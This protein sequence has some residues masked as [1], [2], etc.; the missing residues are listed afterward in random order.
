MGIQWQCNTGWSETSGRLTAQL[1]SVLHAAAR[2]IY[3]KQKYEHI[4]PLLME[5]HWLSV[6]ERIQFKLTVLVFHCLHG[7]APSYLANPLQPVA[8]L[9]SRRRLRSSA[10]AKLDIQRVRRTTVGDRAS[11]SLVFTCGT[12]CRHR[13]RMHFRCLYLGCC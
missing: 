3:S 8:A 7:T 10:S 1:Q 11:V 2:L 6:H 12:A 13:R 5:L 4:T 9:E